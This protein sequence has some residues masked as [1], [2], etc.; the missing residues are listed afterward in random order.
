MKKLLLL[1]L[2][3]LLFAAPA[4]SAGPVDGILDDMIAAYGGADNLKKLNSYVSLWDMKVQVRNE[5]GT[6]RVSVAQPGS[7]RVKLTYPTKT[8]SRVVNA[9]AGYKQ[10]D[11]GEKKPAHGPQLYAMKL[12]L[13]RLY[14]PLVLKSFSEKI[15]VSDSNG[16]KVLSLTDGNISSHYF[17]NPKTRLIDAVIGKLAIAGRPMEFVTEYHDYKKIDGVFVHHM[18]NKFAQGMNTAKLYLKELKSG[19]S[20]P[21]GTFK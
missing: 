16:Y 11:G 7:L 8:E 18:E 10:Y 19:V 21:A 12:Q 6:A 3:I 2:L 13:M 14:S 5:T 1:P 20:H 9:G 15:T 17:V 4:F